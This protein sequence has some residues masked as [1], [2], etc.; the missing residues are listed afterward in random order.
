MIKPIFA[1][2]V[3]YKDAFILPYLQEQ[4][5]KD[6]GIK[7]DHTTHL[8]MIIENTKKLSDKIKGLS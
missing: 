3:I 4:V 7:I 1:Y 5:E 2:K 6:F 8:K